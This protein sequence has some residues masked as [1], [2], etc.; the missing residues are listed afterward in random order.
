MNQQECNLLNY[1][2]EECIKHKISLR[3]ENC[4]MVY[5]E[6]SDSYTEGWFDESK[7]EIIVAALQHTEDFILTLTHEFF[8]LYHWLDNKQD[9]KQINKLINK[10][11]NYIN[12]RIKRSKTTNIAIDKTQDLELYCEKQTIQ[13]IKD[14]KIPYNI[15][16]CVKKANSYLY[17][18][19]VL[20]ETGKWYNKS[21]STIKEILKVMPI[22]FL[23]TYEL[24][25]ELLN[26]YK[27][28]CYD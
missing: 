24:N 12:G 11:N 6:T 17:S 27:K 28:Y 22:E 21:P 5:D 26:L 7:K 23:N 25:E 1:I 14:F 16:T 2:I 18:Y 15:Y 8:H 13:L 20:K 9:Y 19:S 4:S 10:M 3:L